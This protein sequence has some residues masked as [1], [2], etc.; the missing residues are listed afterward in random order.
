MR[1]IKTALRKSALKSILGCGVLLI[2]PIISLFAAE[3]TPKAFRLMTEAARYSA[4]PLTESGELSNGN[5]ILYKPAP[6]ED[7][8]SAD[9]PPEGA[10][11]EEEVPE[12]EPP[13]QTE[14]DEPEEAVLLS[15]NISEVS[16]DLSTFSENSGSIMEVTFTDNGGP[17]FINLPAGGQL[18][19]C[20]DLPGET[21]YSEAVKPH[22][23][24]LSMYSSEPQVLIIHTH[25]SESYEPV[26]K[27]YYDGDYICRSEDPDNSVVAVGTAIA[28]ELASA[29]IAVLHDG[30]LHDGQYTGAYTRSLSTTRD[31]LDEFPSIKII[32]DIHRD[33]IEENDGTRIS[34]VTE[35]EGKKAAQVMIISAADDGTYDMPDYLENLRFA[36]AL[37]QSMSVLYPTLARPVLFQYCQYNQQL[38][39]GSLLI[40]VG[41]HGNS[42]DQAVYSGRLIGRSLA[43][44]FACEGIETASVSG[45]VPRFFIDRLR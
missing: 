30:T 11:P 1:I 36:S 8:P 31:I 24:K 34:A 42:I 27:S 7:A 41:S 2:S 14:A 5:L 29:G 13:V 15:R 22:S 40:E 12:D 32:L 35:I 37:Q 17:D 16:E 6:P 23:I 10:S 38:S 26:E 4:Y 33:A 3:I 44:M 25:T 39:T 43:A 21:V 28:E 45:N 19:N 18:R 9:N 20:T